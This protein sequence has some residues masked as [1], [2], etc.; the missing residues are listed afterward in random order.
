MDHGQEPGEGHGAPLGDH[1]LLGDATLQEALT[2]IS[3]QSSTRSASSGMSRLPL[4]LFD[5]G[6]RG[7]GDEALGRARG[8]AT[9]PLRR[10][11][12]SSS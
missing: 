12:R 11:K 1:V 4:G 3:P 10:P 2:G 5:E 7:G 9:R 8:G 6:L